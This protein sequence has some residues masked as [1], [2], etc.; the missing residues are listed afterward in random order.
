VHPTV[1]TQNFQHFAANTRFK[2]GDLRY[3]G[4]SRST[5]DPLAGMLVPEDDR[6][7]A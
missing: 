2:R 5:L 1:C 7:P 3:I 4:V 6:G